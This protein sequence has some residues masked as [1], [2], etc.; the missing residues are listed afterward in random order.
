MSYGADITDS[1]RRAALYIDKIIKGVKPADL[2]VDRSL[3]RCRHLDWR[4]ER[5]LARNSWYSE[6]IGVVSGAGRNP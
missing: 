4:I 2:P 5:L 3:T 1:F 6:P